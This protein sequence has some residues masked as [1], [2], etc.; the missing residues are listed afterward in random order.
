MVK[1]F[2]TQPDKT[3][4]PA[5]APGF[6]VL[7]DEFNR[8]LS[9]V[10]PYCSE[11]F[12]DRA[13]LAT[14][15]SYDKNGNTIYDAN[16][17]VSTIAYNLLN[18]PEIVQFMQGHQ[19]RYSYS[20]GGKKLTNNSYMLTTVVIVPQG[21]IN[22]VPGSNF[23]KV[24][25][26][27]IGN[28]IYQNGYLKQIQ[29]SEG[30]YQA[31]V[32]Y[33]YLKDHLGNTRAVINSSGTMIEKS[34]YYPFGMRFYQANSS[35]INAIAF[36]YNGKE[37]DSMNGLNHYDFGARSYDPSLGRW[38]TMDLH[39]E[40]YYSWSPYH[41]AA[42]NP[43]IMTDPDGRDWY[44]S[45][46]GS[47]TMW[48]KGNEEIDGYKKLGVYYTQ[49]IS[50]K[51]TIKW[52]QNE[53]VEMTENVLNAKDYESQMT[54]KVVNG[55]FEKKEGNY[56]DCRVNSDKMVKNSGAESLAGEANNEKGKDGID[57][58]NSQV[59]QGY[60]AKVQVDASYDGNLDGQGDHWVAISSRTMN[61]KTQTAIS[62][63]FA[64]PAG[65]WASEG[66]GTSFSVDPNYQLKGSP[67]YNLNT[68][69]IIVNV[70]KNKK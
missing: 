31:G 2:A 14:E 38:N 65:R 24:T 22:P 26:D 46:D 5:I 8:S 9:P 3:I 51:V 45:T 32:Y 18:L 10:L 28:I 27:Y 40:N 1:T 11:A 33:Y 50:D 35:N 20:A 53:Q 39:A 54:G 47:A 62:F 13:K 15:Y 67:K 37:Y 56:G 19:N 58:L 70:R 63:G 25:T 44:T 49:K 59:N 34:H 69:Y 41:Y 52:E 12:N 55:R 60:S 66:M 4:N 48:R 43:L 42:N 68:I 57:Y 17:G 6:V 7:L 16:G 30:Y 64:D 29:T 61:L 23:T 36:R 21:T